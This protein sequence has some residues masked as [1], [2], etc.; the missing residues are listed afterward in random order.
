MP[1][2]WPNDSLAKYWRRRWHGQTGTADF[3]LANTE[4]QA[5]ARNRSYERAYADF[6]IRSMPLVIERKPVAET[7]SFQFVG[8]G[9]VW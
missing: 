1:D 8:V 2:H 3:Y 4:I 7:S 6:M 5:A 9:E